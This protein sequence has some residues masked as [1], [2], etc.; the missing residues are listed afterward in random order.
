MMAARLTKFFTR[1]TGSHPNIALF[2]HETCF[3]ERR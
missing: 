3:L 1:R 2:I